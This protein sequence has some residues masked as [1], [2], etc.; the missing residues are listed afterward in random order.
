MRG[1]TTLRYTSSC[2]LAI[3]KTLSNWNV[4]VREE[5]AFSFT[6]ISLVVVDVTNKLT[7][8]ITN[9][10]LGV[11]TTLYERCA[12]SFSLRGRHL[13]KNN[14]SSKIFT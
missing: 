7:K 5:R 11:S 13:K 12:F 2:L 10:E 3:P 4:L 9:L 1:S 8:T 6:V 14:L